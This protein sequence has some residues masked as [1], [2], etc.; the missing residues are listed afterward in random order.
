[1]DQPE[2]KERT[3]ADQVGVVTRVTR[4]RVRVKT[5]SGAEVYRA[6]TNVRP[7]GDGAGGRSTGAM[8]RTGTMSG[9]NQ[10]M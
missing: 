1:M 3:M 7:L 8:A 10:H 6:P 4:A 9:W 2:G 5:D